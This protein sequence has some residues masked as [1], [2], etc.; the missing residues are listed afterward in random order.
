MSIDDIGSP[1]A[2]QQ[3]SD[4]RDVLCSERA[5]VQRGEE[6]GQTSLPRAVPPY[7][8]DYWCGCAERLAFQP[9]GLDEVLGTRLVAIHGDQHDCVEDHRRAKKRSRIAATPSGSAGPVS[10]TQSSMN[11]SRARRRRCSWASIAMP[12]LIAPDRPPNS[13]ASSSSSARSSS[14]R[15]TVVVS[16][17]PATYHTCATKRCDDAAGARSGLARACRAST[18]PTSGILRLKSHNSSPGSLVSGVVWQRATL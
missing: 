3:R 1:G 5:D 12:C 18:K 7:L 9:S 11:L 8:R 16:V 15:R 6:P 14:L 10:E 13:E 2:A 4:Q 17:T